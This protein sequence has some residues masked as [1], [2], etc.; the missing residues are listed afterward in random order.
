MNLMKK[1][2]LLLLSATLLAASCKKDKVDPPVTPPVTPTAKVKYVNGCTNS[3][4]LNVKV[5][6]ANVADVSGLAFL[7]SSAYINTT[8]GANTPLVFW[9]SNSGIVLA[10]TTYTLAADNYYSAY[11]GGV[12]PGNAPFVIT[13]DNLNA[14][15]SGKAKVRFVNLSDEDLNVDFYVGGPKIDSAIA[16][17]EFTPFYEITAGSKN[18]VIADPIQFGYSINMNAYNFE[19]GKIYTF[20]M[21]GRKT[22]IN[23]AALKATVVNN[24]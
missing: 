12:T 11:V 21:T 13:E 17:K 23:D 2:K 20:I 7:A 22:G 19:T 1:L 18:V 24:N 16:F 5:N 3:N 4:T 8:Y 9:Y 6:D 14:P 10:D 15:A